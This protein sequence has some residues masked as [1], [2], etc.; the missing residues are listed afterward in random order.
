MLQTHCG[1]DATVYLRFLRGTFFWTALITCT[2][3]PTLL[4]INWLESSDEI[5]TN[6]IE[7][8][9][10]SSLIKSPNGVRLLWVHVICIWFLTFTWFGTLFWVALGAVRIR[11]NVVRA[12]LEDEV[13]RHQEEKVLPPREPAPVDARDERPVGWRFRTV[14]MR[15]IGPAM[16]SEEAISEYFHRHLRNGD[17]KISHSSS[18]SPPSASAD[19][20]Y[21]N[22]KDSETKQHPLIS[23]VI[24][25]RKQSEL[26]EL[27]NKYRAVLY[28]LESAHCALAENVIRFVQAK[29]NEEER[30][31]L[32]IAPKR[33][34]FVRLARI[35]GRKEEDVSED[36]ERL[37]RE[38]DSRL[39]AA[40]RGFLPGASSPPQDV[41]GQP[42]SLWTVLHSLNSADPTTLDR[43]QPLFKLRHFRGQRIPS[44]DYHLAKLNLLAVLISDQ[45]AH[46]EAFEAAP[47]AFITFERAA[48]ARRARKELKWRPG[49]KV[50]AGKILECKIKRAPEVR[51]L[52]WNRLVYVSLSADILRGALLQ[53][54]IWGE[55]RRRLPGAK[56]ADR[57]S[58]AHSL[59]HH[60][61]SSAEFARRIGERSPRRSINGNITDFSHS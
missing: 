45:R 5:S 47:S 57:L 54:F 2:V 19:D 43:F 28:E 49:G 53:F 61:G 60:L 20:P 30:V 4:S 15:N 6:S 31:K 46:P 29:V 10:L 34:P 13:E 36:V 9:S 52:D 12:L 23:D 17:P 25:V 14:L 7:R 55:L 44:I 27:Y 16:R 42:T 32:G 26:N 38:G 35:L 24:I 51:D 59:H 58:R 22:T 11:R 50:Y 21:G 3:F 48:D 41:N 39:V 56:V 37:A 40:L 33:R 8:A 18:L 1:P